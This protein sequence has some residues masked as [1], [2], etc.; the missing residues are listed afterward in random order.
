MTEHFYSSLI[1]YT[2]LVNQV[3]DTIQ[4]GFFVLNYQGEILKTNKSFQEFVGLGEGK[5]L[6]TNFKDT[7][8][9]LPIIALDML[10]N[11]IEHKSTQ[12][13]DFFWEEKNKWF[14]FSIYP[15]E[16]GLTGIFS[17]ITEKKIQEEKIKKSEYLL[18]AI[19]NST[20]D[21][22]I[23]VD[24]KGKILSFNRAATQNMQ[25]LYHKELRVGQ[26]MIEEYGL[27][28]TKES[29]TE[30]FLEALSGKEVDTERLLSFPNGEQVWVSLRLFPVFNDKGEVWAVSLNYI[31]IDI[32]KKQH[33]QLEEIARLQSHSVRR[34][35][36]S[37]LGL[38]DLLEKD[39]LSQ[40][41]QKIL[42]Y[43]KYAALELDMVIHQIV[44][45]TET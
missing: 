20:S 40:E 41:N 45:K 23:L 18:K 33:A 36:T 3:L 10:K 14:H 5:I 24:T 6:G 25:S 11:G 19:L 29:F 28:N 9:G 1:S 35:L 27:P 22:N 32:L 39:E 37:I 13:N 7:L 44:K 31:N 2:R 17:N 38:I 26:S 43:L 42:D 21:T 15:F 12:E 34:P 4:E 16:E 30:D 8:A